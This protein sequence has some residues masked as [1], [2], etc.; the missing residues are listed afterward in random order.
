M[1]ISSDFEKVYI[2]AVMEK[3]MQKKPNVLLITPLNE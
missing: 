1:L 3:T 2:N